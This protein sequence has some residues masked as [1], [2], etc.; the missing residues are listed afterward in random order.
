MIP[1][2]EL[3]E[4]LRGE[5]ISDAAIMAMLDPLEALAALESE[6]GS[7]PDASERAEMVRLLRAT[8]GEVGL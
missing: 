2:D 5:E 7:G 1:R 6:I 8:A 4:M 3:A